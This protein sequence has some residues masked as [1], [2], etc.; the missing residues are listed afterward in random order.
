M[1]M[2][3]ETFQNEFPPPPPRN[4]K[5]F[6]LIYVSEVLIIDLSGPLMVVYQQH[7]L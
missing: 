4:K 5:S 6:I 1:Q 3:T 2:N 7:F